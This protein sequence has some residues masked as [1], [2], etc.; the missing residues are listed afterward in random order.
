MNY[1]KACSFFAILYIVLIFFGVFI[2][3]VLK[4]TPEVSLNIVALIATT[5]VVIKLNYI[6]FFESK[7]QLFFS[8]FGG[9]NTIIAAYLLAVIFNSFTQPT[10]NEGVVVFVFNTLVIYLTIQV[11]LKKT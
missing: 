1:I 9:G 8:L 10:I 3:S 6:N 2:N 7:S 11:V 4:I 5:F